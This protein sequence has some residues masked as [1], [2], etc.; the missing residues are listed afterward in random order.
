MTT[1]IYIRSSKDGSRYI[2]GTEL[3]GVKE[4]YCV[5]ARAFGLVSECEIGEELDFETVS[6]LKESDGKYRAMK[7]ALSLL[8][9]ADNNKKTLY[10]KLLRAGF[11]KEISSATVSECERL[12]YI[13]I[14]I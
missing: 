5:D 7:K 11:S 10:M 1:L 6:A 14:S 12:G 8:A 3:D 2:V 13:I 4:E 9:Y